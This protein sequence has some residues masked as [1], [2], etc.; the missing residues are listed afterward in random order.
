MAD[1]SKFPFVS[2]YNTNYN[3]YLSAQNK[4]VSQDDIINFIDKSSDMLETSS[5]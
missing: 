5:Y 3:K 4:K 2:Y 1:V